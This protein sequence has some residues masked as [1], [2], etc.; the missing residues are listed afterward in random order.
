MRENNN[1]E[2]EAEFLFSQD[3]T[4]DCGEIEKRKQSAKTEKSAPKK[5][6]KLKIYSQ[7]ER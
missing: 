5:K 3:L 7:E 1:N 4:S 6:S 2:Q